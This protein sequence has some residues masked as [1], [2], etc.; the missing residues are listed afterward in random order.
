MIILQNKLNK[1]FKLYESLLDDEGHEIIK[2]GNSY[3]F[4][5]IKL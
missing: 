3:K 1:H 4:N 5:K 2:D